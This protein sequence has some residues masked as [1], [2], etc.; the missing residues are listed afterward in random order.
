M[1]HHRQFCGDRA[2][3]DSFVQTS[4]DA[5]EKGDFGYV[6]ENNESKEYL[7][8]IDELSNVIAEWS[9]VSAK[10]FSFDGWSQSHL[11]ERIFKLHPS[12]IFSLCKQSKLQ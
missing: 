1:I 6:I 8:A 12:T 2:A 5:T 7:F 11:L 3:I 9:T 4:N 10:R